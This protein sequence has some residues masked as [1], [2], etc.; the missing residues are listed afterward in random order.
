MFDSL[1]WYE[2]RYVSFEYKFYNK[3]GDLYRISEI[4]VT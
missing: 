1:K 4:D 2:R 3:Q